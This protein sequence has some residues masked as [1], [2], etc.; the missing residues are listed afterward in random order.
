LPTK[1]A[2][3]L[4]PLLE[5]V[6]QGVDAVDQA[7]SAKTLE[8]DDAL[9]LEALKAEAEAPEI[10]ALRDRLDRRIGEA[11]L[12]E[13]LLEV[14]A[15]TRFSWIM[16]GRE[17]NSAEE[18]LMVYA[19]IIAHGTALSAAETA[20]MIPALTAAS[21]RQAMRWVA[22]ERRLAQA[23]AAVL[24]FMQGHSI[25]ASWGRDDLASSDMMS[26][27]TTRRVW[28]ARLDPR[29]NTPSVGIYT[30]VSQRW[31]IFHTQPVVLNERQAGPAIEGMIRQESLDPSQLAVDTHG[32]TDFAMLLAFLLGFDLCPRLKSLKERHLFI[33]RGWKV[34]EALRPICSANVDIDSFPAYWD[35][36]VNL[37][38][39]V[40]NGTS[41]VAVLARFGSCA[42]G[43]PLYESG[44]QIGRLLRT[45]FLADYWTKPEFRREILRVLNRGEAVNALKRQIY[46]GRVAPHQA[47]RME[48]MQAVAEALN[49]LAN[50]LMAWNTTQMQAVLDRWANRRQV[51]P[52]DVLGRIAPTHL[53]GINLRGIF[54]FPIDRFASNLLPSK[55]PP[56]FA[57]GR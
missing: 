51:F 22:D 39:S 29:R 30:H 40:L 11:Q 13:L 5:Q 8:I 55:T 37:T 36:L 12:P 21:V 34:P 15:Q 45:V 38:A 32:Y 57:A 31:G 9:H 46:T 49:L 27:E 14:D 19:G 17:P 25:A 44:V 54:L 28:Q 4:D 56:I 23:N 7:A 33:P 52:N 42:K 6:R 20:R 1:A 2:E 24:T 47:K 35:H 16:L 18:L 53:G 43:D 48:D 50:I 10:Q 26:L 41:A 3:F